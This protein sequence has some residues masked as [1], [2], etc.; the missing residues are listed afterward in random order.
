MGGYFGGQRA[1]VIGGALYEGL[2][3]DGEEADAKL[4][5][6]RIKLGRLSRPR[7]RRIAGRDLH[8]VDAGVRRR[9]RRRRQPAF[10]NFFEG[11][12]PKRLNYGVYDEEVKRSLLFVETSSLR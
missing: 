3:S 2:A 10:C 5:D 8:R 1:A 4:R 12:S 11:Q 7:L 6:G 9:E